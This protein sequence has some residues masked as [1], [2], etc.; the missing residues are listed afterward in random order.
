MYWYIYIYIIYICI[1]E[2]ISPAPYISLYICLYVYFRANFRHQFQHLGEIRAVLQTKVMALTATCTPANRQAILSTLSMEAAVIVQHTSNRPNIFLAVQEM[3]GDYT[4]WQEILDEDIDIL[5]T[6]GITAD[7]KVIFCWS[8]DMACTLYEYYE[9]G[10]GDCAYSNPQSGLTPSNR[11]FAMYHS[12]SASSV[13]TAVSDSLLDPNGVVRRVFA[14]QS[15]GM[16]IDC[17]N[18]REVIHWGVPRSLED[19]LQES[20]RAGRDGLPAKATLL[21]AAHQL[22]EALCNRSVIDYCNS[23]SCYRKVLLDYFCIT[24]EPEFGAA[25]VC[26]SH[27]ACT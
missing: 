16:G 18:I 10:L 22:T 17:P 26:C 8:I 25:S 19:Y 23:Q 6:L 5:K 20:G 4:K 15:L 1:C 9:D 11:I 14:T 12:E 24:A 3:P 7:R 2:I 27:C 21:Y 13:K